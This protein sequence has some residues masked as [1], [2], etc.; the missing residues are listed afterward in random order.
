M[1]K[2]LFPPLAIL[3]TLFLGLAANAPGADTNQIAAGTNAPA[4]KR[5]ARSFKDCLLPAPKNGGFAM[6]GY[7]IWCSSV[8]KVG[9]TYHMFASRWPVQYGLGGWT[10]YS[11]CVRATS[12]NLY[13]PY[14]FQEVVLQKRPDHWD[15]SRVHN[16]KIVKAGDK[17]VIFY[18][19]SANE[20]GYAVSDSITGP[21]T[22]SDQPVIRASNPAPFVRPDGSLYVFCRLRDSSGV[23]RGAAFTAPTYAGPYAVVNHGENLLPNGGELED[24]T[25]W[26]ANNQYNILVNDWKSHATG[27]FKAGAQYFSK[28]GIHYELMSHEPVFTKTVPYDDGTSETF[29]RRE[30]PFV[31]T[32]EKGAVIALF[33]ACMP[34]DEHARV[35]VQPV[36]HYIPGN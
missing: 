14:T 21:W 25:I 15:K 6:D 12:T 34:K 35:V 9:D 4:L 18:I 3:V 2:N 30:R 22:R 5:E 27:I 24:P 16:V 31:Y 29:A 7:I 36:D 32:D 13:G 28:D 23:N 11:E 8:I 26:W 10:K 20:T 17:Y 19:N 1:K 33:T